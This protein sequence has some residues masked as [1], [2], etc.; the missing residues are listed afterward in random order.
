MRFA[1]ISSRIQVGDIVF[2]SRAAFAP[3]FIRLFT[4]SKCSH[5]A[6]CTRPGM[7]LEAVPGGVIRQSVFETYADKRRWLRVLRPKRPLVANAFGLS[8]EHYA[9][10]EYE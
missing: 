10:Q 3:F 1:L 9:E 7:L 5:V 6:M 4:F 2:V 8:V